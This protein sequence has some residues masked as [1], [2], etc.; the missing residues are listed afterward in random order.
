MRFLSNDVFNRL[1]LLTTIQE[2]TSPQALILIIFVDNNQNK[3]YKKISQKILQKLHKEYDTEPKQLAWDRDYP[4]FFWSILLNQFQTP[5]LH[6]ESWVST[7]YLFIFLFYKKYMYNVLS[8]FGFVW[9]T[10]LFNCPYN[11]LFSNL[12]IS[13]SYQFVHS[14]QAFQTQFWCSNA[15]QELHCYL[16]F[17]TYVK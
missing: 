5:H 1:L 6:C 17:P 10:L 16:H 14:I 3:F 7:F 11:K 12:V 15:I 8:H 13:H 4:S 2:L 9:W